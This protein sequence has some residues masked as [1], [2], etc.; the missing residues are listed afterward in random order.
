[1]AT[2]PQAQRQRPAQRV[3]SSVDPQV[4][5]MVTDPA[6]YFARARAAARLEARTYVVRSRGRQPRPA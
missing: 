5:A 2:D 3:K 4:E 1:M 6:G